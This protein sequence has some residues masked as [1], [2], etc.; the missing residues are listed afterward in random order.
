M[1][2]DNIHKSMIIWMLKKEKTQ[3]LDIGKNNKTILVRLNLQKVIE[4]V[5]FYHHHQK[6]DHYCSHRR[7]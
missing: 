7:S 2:V 1:L 3:N 4:I 6:T 5:I